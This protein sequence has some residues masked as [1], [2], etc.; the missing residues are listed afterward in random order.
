[1]S[2]IPIFREYRDWLFVVD[3]FFPT[4]LPGEMIQFDYCNI[5][6]M[7]WFNHQLVTDWE[8]STWLPAEYSRTLQILAKKNVNDFPRRAA[9]LKKSWPMMHNLRWWRARRKWGMGWYELICFQMTRWFFST[10][11]SNLLSPGRSLLVLLLS[12][13]F[14]LQLIREEAAGSHPHIGK[15]MWLMITDQT[16]KQPKL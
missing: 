2:C 6:Q 10:A 12:H 9:S 4:P 1:M 5:F 7:G 16:S 14:D 3:I 11:T 13:Q 8:L 15:S